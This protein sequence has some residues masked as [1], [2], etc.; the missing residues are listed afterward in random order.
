VSVVTLHPTGGSIRFPDQERELLYRGTDQRGN[1]LG[2][3]ATVR[4]FEENHPHIEFVVA[5]S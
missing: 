3:V 1:P 2:I 4:W 5:E